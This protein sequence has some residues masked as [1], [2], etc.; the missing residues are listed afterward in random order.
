MGSD[1]SAIKDAVLGFL[2]LGIAGWIVSE[3]H[4]M[5]KSVETLNVSLAQILEKQRSMEYRVEKLEDSR[6]EERFN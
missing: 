3:L 2:T 1:L 5:R 6:L 4:A